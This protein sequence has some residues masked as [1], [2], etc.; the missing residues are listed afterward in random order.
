[1][2][3]LLVSA[4]SRA[5]ST[6]SSVFLKMAVQ[7]STPSKSASIS[8]LAFLALESPRFAQSQDNLRRLMALGLPDRSFWCFF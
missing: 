5:C 4:P 2:S 8:M 6:D 1:M 7:W 3:D